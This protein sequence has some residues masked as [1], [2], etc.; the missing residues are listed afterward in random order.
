MHDFKANLLQL[1]SSLEYLERVKSEPITDAI[2]D[3]KAKKRQHMLTMS[4]VL[5]TRLKSSAR[6]QDDDVLVALTE[7]LEQNF[8][9]APKALQVI[10]SMAEYL[11]EN[12]GKQQVQKQRLEFRVSRIPEEVRPDMEADLKEL[13]KCFDAECYRSSVI[14]CGRILETSLH[15]LYYEA[16]GIDALEKNPGI[17]LGKLIAKLTEKNFKFDPG[18]SQQIHLINQVRIFSVHKKKD[19]FYPSKPQTEAIILF[20]LDTVNKLFDARPR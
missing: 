11:A 5:I 12:I 3:F 14:L 2:S 19:V 15:R 9:S 13:R 6:K 10:D 4:R 7:K 1:K 8:S 20:T 17:G 16:A 18:L